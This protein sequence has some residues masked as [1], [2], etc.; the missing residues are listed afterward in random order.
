ML[1]NIIIFIYVVFSTF[2]IYLALF[3]QGVREFCELIERERAKDLILLSRKYA[4]IGS[5][6]TMTERLIMQ[7]SSGKAKNMKQYY[8]YW[9]TKIFD[10]L[11]KMVL[12]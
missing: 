1:N 10:S 11:V 2:I 9:E 12:R 3:F 5:L 8:T 4:D 7:T 6:L